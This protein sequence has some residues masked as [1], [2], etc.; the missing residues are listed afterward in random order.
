[1][2][3]EAPRALSLNMFLLPDPTERTTRTAN[4][5]TESAGQNRNQLFA[6]MD[7]L[8]DCSKKHKPLNKI[9]VR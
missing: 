7:E 6:F 5:K 8:T 2:E 3:N 9:H 1:M 4:R